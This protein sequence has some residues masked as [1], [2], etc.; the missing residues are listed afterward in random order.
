MQLLNEPPARPNSQI[1]RDLVVFSHLRWSWVWQR[2]QHLISRVGEGRKVWFVEEPMP[3]D[4]TEP[5]LRIEPGEVVTRVWLD[6]PAEGRHIG[7][8]EHVLRAYASLIPECLGSADDRI[9]WMYTPLPFDLAA[10]LG[11]DVTV[12]DVMDDLSSF[13]NAPRQLVL[14]HQ[15]ALRDADIVFAGGRTLHRNVMAFRPDARL[16]ASGVEP[17]H[18]QAAR[19]HRRPRRR[20]VA[21]YVGVIDER[22]DLTL[23]GELASALPDWDIQIVGPVAKIDPT[24]L[25]QA[26]NLH[27]PGP[28]SY[29][30]L[31]KVMGGFDVA[32]MPFALNE[33]TRSISPTK[34]LE[35][36]A[37]GLP[38]V[39]T[40]IADVVA[41]FAKVVDLAD[42]AQGF[43]AACKRLLGADP[44]LR[45]RAA[46]PFLVDHHWDT[47]ARKMATI[48]STVS[49]AST[50]VT[51]ADEV[52]A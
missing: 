47:I 10:S 50:S 38:V 8:E 24:A 48:I 5:Q 52:S 2:P 1:T 29:E 13:L 25:P 7:F 37:A 28:R 6:V 4:V 34:T 11:A 22:L 36:L 27:Y 31:P 30:E 26:K 3:A 23:V 43:A 21:G 32:L 39:S 15:R 19:T 51:P 35:Y 46:R 9:V 12:Y 40:R 14:S 45:E 33:A 16:F 44:V 18:Y 20:P 42:D 17:E 41:D 49:A